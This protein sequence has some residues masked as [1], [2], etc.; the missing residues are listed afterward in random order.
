M[1][2]LF[3][4][5]FVLG[6]MRWPSSRLYVVAE[7]AHPP[8]CLVLMRD[9]STFFW[10]H[11]KNGDHLSCVK[12]SPDPYH[13]PRDFKCSVTDFYQLK[14]AVSSRESA[15][16]LFLDL[17]QMGPISRPIY[18]CAFCSRVAERPGYG[19]DAHSQV[20]QGGGNHKRS[21]RLNFVLVRIQTISSLDLPFSVAGWI[22]AEKLSTK[23]IS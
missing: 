6:R 4:W 8:L 21:Q 14:S 16:T 13:C 2:Y 17:N 9:I 22:L 20:T 23:I 3:Q 18:D 11:I 15:L 12:V 7:F 1:K 19:S 5:V 10:F